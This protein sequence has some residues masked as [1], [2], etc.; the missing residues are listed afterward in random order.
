MN[1]LTL[2]LFVALPFAVFA[3]SI[4]EYEDDEELAPSNVRQEPVF[5]TGNE[6]QPVSPPRRPAQQPR[7]TMSRDEENFSGKTEVRTPNRELSEQEKQ[8]LMK[9]LEE[10]S[11]DRAAVWTPYGVQERPAFHCTYLNNMPGTTVCCTFTSY[12][13]LQCYT[14]ANYMV[15]W[16]TGYGM[17]VAGPGMG[18]AGPGV[19]VMG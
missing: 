7:P 3:G 10:T 18:V 13:L 8:K 16:A 17:G 14:P 19:G 4:G 6:R 15:P 11:E 1:K 9:G 5:N 2:L 12:H